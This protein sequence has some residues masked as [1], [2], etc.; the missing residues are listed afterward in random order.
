MH[1]VNIFNINVEKRPGPSMPCCPQVRCRAKEKQKD[2]RAVQ[3]GSAIPF[4]HLTEHLFW[5]R[6][7]LGMQRKGQRKRSVI[8]YDTSHHPVILH[9]IRILDC[10]NFLSHHPASE[11]PF[12]HVTPTARETW[13]VTGS[14]E[15]M[16]ELGASFLCLFHGNVRT[17]HTKRKRTPLSV[18]LSLS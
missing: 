10:I 13:R 17:I 12:L 16:A 9:K 2:S 5:P 4:L 6:S 3:Q 1:F 7:Y 8:K 11:T 18:W 14:Q 15:E